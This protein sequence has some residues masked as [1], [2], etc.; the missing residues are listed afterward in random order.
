VEISAPEAVR[1]EQARKRVPGEGL[2][3]E[4]SEL[5]AEKRVPWK[6]LDTDHGCLDTLDSIPPHEYA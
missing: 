2:E 5:G 1:P 3:V 4:I 6:I